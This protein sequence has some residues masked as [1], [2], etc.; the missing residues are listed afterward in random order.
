MPWPLFIPGKDLV[1]I[2]QK[3]GWA[4]GPIWT[5]AENVAPIGIW[6]PD[7]PAC[8]ELLYQLSY[9]A[10][11]ILCN[12]KYTISATYREVRLNYTFR[13]SIWSLIWCNGSEYWLWKILNRRNLRLG[14]WRGYCW[15]WMLNEIWVKHESQEQCMGIL[16]CYLYI[17]TYLRKILK[18]FCSD[19]TSNEDMWRCAQEKYVANQVKL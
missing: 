16:Q 7:H 10:H 3:A 17:N 9:P 8:S 11:T 4:P 15:N 2:V 12:R 19:V 13:N 14:L 5:D 18:I 6:S 1:P